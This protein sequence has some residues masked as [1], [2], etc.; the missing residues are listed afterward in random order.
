[1][2]DQDVLKARIGARIRAR[3]KVRR[4]FGVWAKVR[5][6]FGNDSLG[7]FISQFSA[8]AS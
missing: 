4:S 7:Q 2:F 6:G 3:A 1:M 8:F 5:V